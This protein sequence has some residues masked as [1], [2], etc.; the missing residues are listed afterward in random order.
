M[1][2]Q[3]LTSGK[4]GHTLNATQVFS[5]DDQWVVYDTRN[6]DTHIGRTDGIEM[7]NVTTGKVV[8]LYTT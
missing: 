3:Q 2:E 8:R 4:Y 1:P 6:D 7:V 5:P